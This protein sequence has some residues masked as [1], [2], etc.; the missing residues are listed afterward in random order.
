VGIRKLPERSFRDGLRSGI[1]LC[2]ELG[3]VIV[4]DEEFLV[5]RVWLRIVVKKKKKKKRRRRRRR[6]RRD[7][8][9]RQQPELQ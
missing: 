7:Y 5:F 3:W 6:R 2:G 1:N 9:G 4:E 8:D